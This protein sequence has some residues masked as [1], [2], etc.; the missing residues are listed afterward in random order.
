MIVKELIETLEQ[1]LQSTVAI[2]DDRTKL[3]ISYIETVE[4]F[5]KILKEIPST[6]IVTVEDDTSYRISYNQ[7]I[8]YIDVATDAFHEE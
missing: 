1:M 7:H 6:T 3:S 8:Y 4:D 2:I 5:I